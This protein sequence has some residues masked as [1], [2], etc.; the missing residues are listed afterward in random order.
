MLIGILVML[1]IR[2]IQSPATKDIVD[3]LLRTFWQTP[4]ADRGE[5]KQMVEEG[6]QSPSTALPALPQ[7]DSEAVAPLSGRTPRSGRMS[8]LVDARM[9]LRRQAPPP[10]A[11]VPK[12]KLPPPPKQPPPRKLVCGAP[13]A[14]DSARSL[15]MPSPLKIG[16]GASS[17]RVKYVPVRPG[18]IAEVRSDG[19]AMETTGGA[20]DK[21]Q[22]ILPI[23]LKF[24]EPPTHTPRSNYNRLSSILLS[25][26]LCNLL[27]GVI[28][29]LI[30]FALLALKPPS[31]PDFDTNDHDLVHM[32]LEESIPPAAS[33]SAPPPPPPPA[34]PP[35]PPPP[36]QPD[37]DCP[38]SSTIDPLL[39]LVAVILLNVVPF[40][41]LATRATTH[42]GYKRFEDG[43]ELTA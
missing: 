14:S 4:R 38:I 24:P 36:S 21:P 22:T 25:A 11:S 41:V 23:S 42:V 27:C 32:F 28:G 3:I 2:C 12:L 34:L 10:A 33:P 19:L 31:A 7:V 16:E 17:T 20:E 43:S 8:F 9:S 15:V 35:P 5:R 1:V 37:F 30:L 6:A 26:G 29:L 40:A 39:L 13:V 18:V